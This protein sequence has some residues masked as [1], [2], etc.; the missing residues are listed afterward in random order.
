MLDEHGKSIEPD[1]DKPKPE[2]PKEQSIRE[3]TLILTMKIIDGVYH[4]VGIKKES[5][6]MENEMAALFMLEKAKDIVK[7]V[8]TPIIHKALQQQYGIMNFARKIM[9][10]G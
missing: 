8:H 6:A 9:E 5:T 1:N 10:K 4:S 2:Q 7:A 3:M